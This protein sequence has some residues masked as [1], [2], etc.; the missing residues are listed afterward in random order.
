MERKRGRKK[1]DVD[2][3]SFRLCGCALPPSS[4]PA[5]HKAFLVLLV[6]LHLQQVN[7]NSM[8]ATA[9]GYFFPVWYNLDLKICYVTTIGAIILPFGHMTDDTSARI[10][11]ERWGRDDLIGA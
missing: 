5:R 8:R 2:C 11:R 3:T 7:K 9:P 6:F 10:I 1:G 4:K